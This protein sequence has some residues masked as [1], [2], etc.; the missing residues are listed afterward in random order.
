LQSNEWNSRV[1][2]KGIGEDKISKKPAECT[3][4]LRESEKDKNRRIAPKG[5]GCFEVYEQQ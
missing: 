5:A 1:N 4:A 3:I 2:F